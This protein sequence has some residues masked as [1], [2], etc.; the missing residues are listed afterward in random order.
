MTAGYEISRHRLP[1]KDIANL[2]EKRRSAFLLA[3]KV[4]NELLLLQRLVIVHEN[5]F[6]ASGV[7]N[8]ERDCQ[9]AMLFMA[10]TLLAA[11]TFEAFK[12]LSSF[13]S[14]RRPGGEIELSVEGKL[15]KIE[16]GPAP[17]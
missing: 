14:L 4:A 17:R 3:S 1:L 16:L 7:A 15:A 8:T 9:N 11:K 5:G 6:K 2:N 12:A 13:G 10:L